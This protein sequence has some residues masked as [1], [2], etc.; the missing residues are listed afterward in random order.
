MSS[1][2]EEEEG[3]ATASKL[4][5]KSKS[6]DLGAGS[7]K[8]QRE[9]SVATIISKDTQS[10]FAGSVVAPPFKFGCQKVYTLLEELEPKKF[11]K[12]SSN[13]GAKILFASKSGDLPD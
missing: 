1:K 5:D 12:F 13:S 10:T 7:P 3:E 8:L 6:L 4:T 11:K 9:L 2:K